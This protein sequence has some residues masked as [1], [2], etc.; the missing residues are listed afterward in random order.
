MYLYY[1]LNDNTSHLFT[2]HGNKD[3]VCMGDE[4]LVQIS[5]DPIKTKKGVVTSDIEL[6]GKYIIL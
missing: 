5:K 1:S 4:L 6:N 3:K 2:Q